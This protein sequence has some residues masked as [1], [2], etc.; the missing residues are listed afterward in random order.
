MN[1][2]AMKE[3]MPGSS[4]N[5]DF[6]ISNSGFYSQLLHT[7]YYFVRRVG[8]YALISAITV[9]QSPNKNEKVITVHN[10]LDVLGQNCSIVTH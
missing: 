3:I 6:P 7:A 8:L 5:S 10:L 4:I 9:L 2:F 1:L